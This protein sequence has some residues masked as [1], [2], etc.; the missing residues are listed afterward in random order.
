MPGDR[1]SAFDAVLVDWRGTLALPL[2]PERWVTAALGGLGRPASPVDAAPVLERLEAVDADARLGTAGMDADPALHRRI[3]M[4]VLADAGLDSALAEA[5]YRVESDPGNDGFAD[6]VPA[7][8]ARTRA[9]GIRIVLVSDIHVDVRPRFHA[10]GLSPYVDAYALSCEH[11]AEKPD[12]RLFEAALHMAGSRP[13]EAVM[14]GDRHTHDGGAAALGV[15]TLI[16]PPLRAATD[17]RLHLAEALLY[18]R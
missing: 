7:F 2:A 6:D 14:V 9:A 10:A 16:L 12:P 18:G 11:G 4:E 15:T 8:L 13:D 1:A 3:F 5:L 17:R